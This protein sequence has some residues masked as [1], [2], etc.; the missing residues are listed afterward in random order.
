MSSR[1][2]ICLKVVMGFEGGYSNHRY[3][4][5]GLTI[6]GV[7]AATLRQAFERGVVGHNEI[8]RLTVEEARDIYQAMYWEPIG[9]PGLPEPLDLILFD[10]AVNHGVGGAG[11]L[12][13]R[14][15]N[16][17]IAADL[18]IDGVIGQK[19]V[20]ALKGALNGN[21]PEALAL[22][23]LAMRARLYVKIVERDARQRE[24]LWGWIRRRV[25]ELIDEIK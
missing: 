15:L 24:F 11:Q 1:F 3:D 19:T 22:A 10:C 20:E 18:R 2:E 14:T 16:F 13:Q 4:T 7:T 12:L 6:Y 23:V 5:G 21:S 17:V 8:R 25:A 9:A